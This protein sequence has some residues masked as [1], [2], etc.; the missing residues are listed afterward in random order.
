M[1]FQMILKSAV[2]FDIIFCDSPGYSVSLSE[3]FGVKCAQNAA[4]I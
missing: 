3:E 2:K 1:P 4:C